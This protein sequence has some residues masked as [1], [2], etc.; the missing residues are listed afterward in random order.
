MPALHCFQPNMYIDIINNNNN[1][2]TKSTAG[3]CQI[4]GIS[5]NVRVAHEQSRRLNAVYSAL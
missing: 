4:A 2:D 5:Q 3:L 1:I